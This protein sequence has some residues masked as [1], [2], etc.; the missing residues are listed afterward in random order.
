MVN[1]IKDGNAMEI[2]RNDILLLVPKW[3]QVAQGDIKELLKCPWIAKA[4][5]SPEA[6]T[7]LLNVAWL[8]SSTGSL[9]GKLNDSCPHYRGCKR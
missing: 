9:E 8:Y 6:D 3:D 4:L 5:S 7:G 2:V 1:R